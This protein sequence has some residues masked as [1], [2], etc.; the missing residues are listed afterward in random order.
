[1]SARALWL[2]LAILACMWI[3]LAWC[4]S[5]EPVL[6]DGWGPF[7]W[8]REVGLSLGS[9][10]GFAEGSYLHNNPRLG[11]IFTWLMFTPGP[12]H[13]IIT[14]VVEIGVVLLSTTLALGRWPSWR[15]SDDAIL[16]SAVAAMIY[17]V[18]PEIGPMFFYRPFSG[19]YL[20]GFALYLVLYLPYRFAVVRQAERGLVFAIVLGI[21]AVFTGLTNEHTGPASI[22]AIVATMWWLRGQTRAWMWTGLVGLVTGYAMLFFAPGQHER[23]N[24]LAEQAGPLTLILDRG[25]LGNL[26]IVGI[27]AL[28]S[29]QF[30]PWLA[31]VIAARRKQ[32]TAREP[33]PTAMVFFVAGLLMTV[34]LLASPKQ[35]GR[36]YFSTAVMWSISLAIGLRPT[37][38]LAWARN[39]VLAMSAAVLIFFGAHF[40]VTYRAVDAEFT[41]RL[42]LLQAAPADSALV[43]PAYE[44]KHSRWVLGDD[45]FSQDLCN[46]MAK[47][48]HLRS[49]TREPKSRP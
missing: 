19:N 25:V 38:A 2:W 44:T 48:F 20:Y 8:H 31:V 42:A 45:F 3:P 30:L 18:A 22:F 34:V 1:M 35:G 9:L 21:W 10:W 33:A 32:V 49:L 43:V 40:V 14:P 11:Q 4:C 23:Y 29:V 15:R 24:G 28:T 7:W 12:W 47:K 26:R 41:A 17:L 27:L 13:A 46:R 37:F 36:L 39:T 16:F 5:L 6:H